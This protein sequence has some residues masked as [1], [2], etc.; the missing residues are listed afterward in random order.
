[1]SERVAWP[2]GHLESPAAAPDLGLAH[3]VAIGPGSDSIRLGACADDDARRL[4]P[5]R[6][7]GPGD[8]QPSLAVEHATRDRSSGQVDL[9][10]VLLGQ[11]HLDSRARDARR[12][13]RAELEP[14]VEGVG[15]GRHALEHD[16]RRVSRE[17]RVRDAVRPVEGQPGASATSD[18]SSTV[19]STSQS[20]SPSMGPDELL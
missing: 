6:E 15:S 10:L 2:E 1:M 17:V 20:T 4:A 18:A 19:V 9:E 14:R 11:R 3:D 8:R 12:A 16:A 13:S 5:Q 7:A